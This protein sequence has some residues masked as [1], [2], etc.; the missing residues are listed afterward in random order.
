[1]IMQMKRIFLKID[2]HHPYVVK[3]QPKSDKN[4]KVSN[5]IPKKRKH[6]L[7]SVCYIKNIR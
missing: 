3:D 7:I 2:K 1:M 4:C 5:S 6:T